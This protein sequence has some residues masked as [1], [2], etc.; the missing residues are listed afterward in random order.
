[1]K[2]AIPHIKIDAL[3]AIDV[4]AIGEALVGSNSMIGWLPGRGRLDIEMIFFRIA[5]VR[6]ARREEVV[7]G[8]VFHLYGLL[9]AFF[10]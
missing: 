10:T 5:D 4:A 1:M 8:G 2:S 6:G 9:S 3:T 7:S